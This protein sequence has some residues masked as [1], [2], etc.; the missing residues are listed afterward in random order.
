[1]DIIIVSKE[2]N[3]LHISTDGLYTDYTLYNK[4]GMEVD[5]GFL[6]GK[7]TDENINKLVSLVISMAKGITDFSSPYQTIEGEKATN[8]LEEIQEKNFD[9]MMQ[10]EKTI[11]EEIER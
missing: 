8:L 9:D 1:M 4:E 11:E 2:N 3:K 5:G 7:T 6:L 10:K